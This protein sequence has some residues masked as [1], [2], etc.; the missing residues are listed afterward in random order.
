MENLLICRNRNRLS[1]INHALYVR[2]IDFAIANSNDAMRA[3]TP[4][5]TTGDAS[6]NRLNLASRHEL[7][8]FDGS[9]NGLHR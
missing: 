3:H 9:L 6:I 4:N 2:L 5:V 8:F 7:S 1:G